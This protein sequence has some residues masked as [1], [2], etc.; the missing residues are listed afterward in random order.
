LSW[1]PALGAG[2]LERHPVD[3]LLLR[4]VW[5][6]AVHRLVITARGYAFELTVTRGA[7]DAP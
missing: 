1:D 3:D 5:G 2:D 6:E 4:E 7:P